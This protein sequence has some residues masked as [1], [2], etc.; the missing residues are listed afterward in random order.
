MKKLVGFKKFK[1]KNG[2][3]LCVACLVGDFTARDIQN[4]SFG[5]NVEQVFLPDTQFNYLT[6]KDIGK[7]VELNYDV[8]NGRAYLSEIVV[9]GR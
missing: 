3:D 6:S 8:V 7:E 9:I 4:G 5:S 2:N 1:S